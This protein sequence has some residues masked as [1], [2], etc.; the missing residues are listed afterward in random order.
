MSK[1]HTRLLPKTRRLLSVIAKKPL[2]TLKN[3]DLLKMETMMSD[4]T[5]LKEL[6]FLLAVMFTHVT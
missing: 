5:E 1:L 6:M 3:N 2:L 4:P